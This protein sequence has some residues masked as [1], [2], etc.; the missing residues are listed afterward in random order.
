MLILALI[1]SS[2][3]PFVMNLPVGMSS[4]IIC[5]GKLLFSR[6]VCAV[7]PDIWRHQ[8]A[9]AGSGHILRLR[10]VDTA[11]GPLSADLGERRLPL[12]PLSY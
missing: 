2:L 5:G 8:H 4:K 3:W 12:C 9:R 7:P 1:H 6:G 10:L 11:R